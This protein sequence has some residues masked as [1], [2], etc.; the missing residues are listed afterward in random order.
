MVAT[1]IDGSDNAFNAGRS[2]NVAVAPTVDN[3][4]SDSE[5]RR[6]WCT[7]CK[8]A[9][10]V[11]RAGNDSDSNE[12]WPVVGKMVWPTVCNSGNSTY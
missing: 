2:A 6:F 8:S 1:D 11:C 12:T 7:I 4:G 3:M 10:I 9:P 5:V